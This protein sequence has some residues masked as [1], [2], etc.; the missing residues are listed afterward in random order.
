MAFRRL[1][2][3]RGDLV[4]G[5]TF[6]TEV[7]QEQ[8]RVARTLSRV[9]A[10][11]MLMLLTYVSKEQS[12]GRLGALPSREEILAALDYERRAATRLADLLR[13]VLPFLAEDGSRRC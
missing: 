8:L 7:H 12:E 5:R 3:L 1:Y 13:S 6:K 9:V 10:L 4:H 11:R 2:E